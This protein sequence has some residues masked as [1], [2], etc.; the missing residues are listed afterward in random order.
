MK[1]GY[2]LYDSFIVTSTFVQQHYKP[3]DYSSAYDGTYGSF[4]TFD[5]V[6][7]KV[8]NGGTVVSSNNWM[9]RIDTFNVLMMLWRILI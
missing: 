2:E 5:L 7:I 1:S 9:D 6:N 3:I 8:I 4:N